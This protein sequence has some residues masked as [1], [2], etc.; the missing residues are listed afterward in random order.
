MT[1]ESPYLDHDCPLVRGE[2][3]ALRR[4]AALL[5]DQQLW[6]WGQDVRYPAGNILMRF[7]FQRE[8]PPDPA[9]G[10]SAYRLFPFSGGQIVLWGFGLFFG[11]E[12]YGG[13]FLRRQQFLPLWTPLATL[14]TMFWEPEHVP[15]LRVPR[16][17]AECVCTR[18]LLTAALQGIACYEQWV[19]DTLGLDYRNHCLSA[20]HNTTVPAEAVSDEWARL[21]RR[22]QE[23]LPS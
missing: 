13:L 7:G 23:L 17:L 9:S 22:S 8:R 20:W 15:E 12:A 2:S 18:R 11:Q 16:T 19:L 1:T 4:R 10:C 21:A 3:A 6:C 5:L 14:P